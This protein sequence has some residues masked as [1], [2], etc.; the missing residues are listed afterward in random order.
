MVYA[1]LLPSLLNERPVSATVPSS[2]RVLGS[3]NTSGVPPMLSM[4]YT[5]LWLREPSF[6]EK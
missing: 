4:R 3:M 1:A 6:A 2:E 5:M